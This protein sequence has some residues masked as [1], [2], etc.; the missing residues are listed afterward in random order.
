MIRI[1]E[2]ALL[3][4][5]RKLHSSIS[6]MKFYVFQYLGHHQYL[7]MAKVCA[8]CGVT[9]LYLYVSSYAT[10]TGQ[11]NGKQV[12]AGGRFRLLPLGLSL[13]TI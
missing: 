9:T 3:F 6:A 1:Q 10:Q 4:L 11:E 13:S 8:Q 2:F 7:A 5:G 12:Q